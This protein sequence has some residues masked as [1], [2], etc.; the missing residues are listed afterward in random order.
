MRLS[1]LVIVVTIVIAAGL[2]GRET[3]A[4]FE[5]LVNKSCAPDIGISQLP[6]D[7]CSW[8]DLVGTI[9]R[10]INVIVVVLAPTL[11]LLFV[12]LGGFM[13]MFGGPFPDRVS[14]GKNM[15]TTALV[16]Y[17]LVLVSGFII[18]L[19][20]GVFQVKAHIP[21]AVQQR[22]NTTRTDCAD[23]WAFGYNPPECERFR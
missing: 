9:R 22:L 14:A 11:A 23:A 1:I 19:V 16:G 13:M 2:P 5:P 18:D 17:I 10:V 12:L 21:E 15:I 20:L 3:K 4:A 7:P 6:G 8:D